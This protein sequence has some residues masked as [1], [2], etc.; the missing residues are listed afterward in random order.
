MGVLFTLSECEAAWGKPASAV[1][2]YDQFLARYEELDPEQK[3]VHAERRRIAEKKRAILLPQVAWLTIRVPTPAPSGTTIKHNGKSLAPET[4]G[5][6]QMVNPGPQVL[7]VE[8][9]GRPAREHRMALQPAERLRFEVA[10]FEPVLPPAKN[11]IEATRALPTAG[12]TSTPAIDVSPESPSSARKWAYILGGT[13]ALSIGVGLV[14]GGLAL[15][16]KPSIDQNCPDRSCN[17]DGRRAVDSAQDL[18]LASTISFAL[19]IVSLSG[20][21]FLLTT[22]PPSSSARAKSP[23]RAWTPVLVGRRGGGSVEVHAVW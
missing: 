7:V 5:S 15:G 19:G 10:L 9:P 2:H 18:A 8:V 16:K 6:P 21:V 17:R 13:G 1:G 3:R 12:K 11:P 14:T 20:A 4:L 23:A 22:D